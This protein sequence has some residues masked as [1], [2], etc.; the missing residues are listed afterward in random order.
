GHG[1]ERE[2]GVWQADAL[3]AAKH[4]ARHELGV[5]PHVACLDDAKPELAVIHQQ[6]VPWPHRLEDLGMWQVR[7]AAA[8]NRLAPCEAQHVALGQPDRT[9]FELADAKLWSLQVD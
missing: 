8:A 6:G 3:A 9:G 5:D 7:T 2:H 1:A 4:A